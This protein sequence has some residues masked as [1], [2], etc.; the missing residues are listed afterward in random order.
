[1]VAS[2]SIEVTHKEVDGN[3]IFEAEQMPG[4]YIAS[5]DPRVAFEAIAPA[6]EKLIKLD[7]GMVVRVAPEIPFTK[8]I[9]T[10]RSEKTAAVA[11]QRFNLF[12][13]A[14]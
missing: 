2:A 14:A 6:I 13:E 11:R 5:A 9:S 3:H 12:Q 7:T 8:F 10:T 4:L 1:M